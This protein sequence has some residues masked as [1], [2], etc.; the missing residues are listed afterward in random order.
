MPIGRCMCSVWFLHM[1]RV[2]ESKGV[3]P[4]RPR[5]RRARIPSCLT[6]RISPQWLL[7]REAFLTL[8]EGW[9]PMNAMGIRITSPWRLVNTAEVPVTSCKFSTKCACI[10][11]KISAPKYSAKQGKVSQD[12]G[13]PDHRTSPLSRLSQILQLGFLSINGSCHSVGGSSYSLSLD[14]F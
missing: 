4:G 8:S 5:A 11:L 7:S 2:V 14:C 1:I 12:P 13:R 6:W 9:N 3:L 10:A